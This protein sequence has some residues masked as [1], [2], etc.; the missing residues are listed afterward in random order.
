MQL[1]IRKVLT[2]KKGVSRC[3]SSIQPTEKGNFIAS[4]VKYSRPK[5]KYGKFTFD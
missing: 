3:E 5:I 2:E 1:Y 4:D